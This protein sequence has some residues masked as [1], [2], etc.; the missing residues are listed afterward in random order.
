MEKEESLDWKFLPDTI[1]YLCGQTASGKST[2]LAALLENDAR[3]LSGSSSHPPNVFYCYGMH[4]PMVHTLSQSPLDIKLVQGLDANLLENLEDHL[5]PRPSNV[6]PDILHNLIIFDD[7]AIP[8]ANSAAFTRL[9]TEGVHHRSTTVIV[10]CHSWFFDG[11]FRRLQMS[12][13]SYFVTFRSPRSMDS[14]C[15]LAQQLSLVS[16]KSVK[17]AF[18][19]ICS[20]NYIPLIIDAHK[21]T[22]PQLSLISN[23]LPEQY[24]VTVYQS[25]E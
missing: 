16:R 18:K 21:D 25:D 15:R 3:L 11:K 19:H 9:L 17:E 20:L 22:H 24:P 14:V 23:I 2:F 10:I 5:H 1:I 4:S 13:G 12:Q 7:L 8:T 6:S